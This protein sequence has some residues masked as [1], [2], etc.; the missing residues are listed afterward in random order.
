MRRPWS[1]W[2]IEKPP[3]GSVLHGAG[4]EGV[5]H[6]SIAEVIGWHLDVP[7]R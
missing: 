3:V 4:D 5:E 6:R 2:R 1:G 7:V